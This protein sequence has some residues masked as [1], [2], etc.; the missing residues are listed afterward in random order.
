VLAGRARYAARSEIN[1]SW[2]VR[3]ADF[4]RRPP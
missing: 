2:T 1:R 3:G 4:N